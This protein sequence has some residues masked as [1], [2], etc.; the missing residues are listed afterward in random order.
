MN[1]FIKFLARRAGFMI[2]TFITFIFIIFI[3]PRS[4]PGNP[5]ATLL[6]QLFQQAQTNPELIKAVHRKL[7]EEFGI[8]K[9]IHIQFFEFITRAFIG[10]LGTSIAF[11][12]R[13]VTEIVFTY[14]PWTLGLLI[15]ATITSWV[16][17]NLLGALAAYKRKTV[18]DNVLLPVFLTLSQTP[19]YWLAMLLLFGLAVTLRIFPIGGAYSPIRL[20]ALTFEF[21][22]DLLH[23]YTLPFLSIVIGA[24]GGW[25]IGMRVMAIYELRADYISYADSLGLPDSKLLKYVFRNS[26]L[27]QITGLALNLGTILGGSLITELVFSYPGTGYLIFRALSTLDY[28]LIQGTFLLLTSTL[29]LA[30]FIVDIMYAYIDPRVRTGYTGE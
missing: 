22:V 28:P 8:G 15:P 10:D 2:L 3:L 26:I 27:P 1:P 4:I 20:P 24:M 25:A 16:I 5:L 18:V 13:K 17:G 6:S 14:L 19:Y 30:N 7:M 11:Y 23:H 12:P 29:L 9:P 21:I